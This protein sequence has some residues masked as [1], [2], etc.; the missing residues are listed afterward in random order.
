[1]SDL[2][3][4]SLQNEIA[5]RLDTRRSHAVKLKTDSTGI[6][7]GLDDDVV[8]EAIGVVQRSSTTHHLRANDCRVVFVGRYELLALS[9]LAR[10][11]PSVKERGQPARQRRTRG[12][13]IV[14][15]EGNKA[16]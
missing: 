14:L 12:P 5:V 6:S 15:A 9:E 3:A 4:A 8:L 16:A 2:A 1:M 11:L 7:A 13:R 10:S